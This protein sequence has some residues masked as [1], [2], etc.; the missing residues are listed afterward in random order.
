MDYTKEAEIS[1]KK[2]KEAE[3]EEKV[4]SLGKVQLFW[5]IQFLW[6]QKCQYKAEYLIKY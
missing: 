5:R 4:R 2:L 1:T 3:T 6:E